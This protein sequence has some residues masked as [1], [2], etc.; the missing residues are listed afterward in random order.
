ML[1][2][3]KVECKTCEISESFYSKLS[4][5]QFKVRHAGHQVVEASDGAQAA[6][7]RRLQGATEDKSLEEET[8]R[9]VSKVIVSM[10]ASPSLGQP[11]VR[12][13]GFG[14]DLEEAFSATVPYNEAEKA[15]EILAKGEFVDYDVTGRRYT[16]EVGSVEY[17]LDA[18]EML[19]APTQELAEEIAPEPE[20]QVSEVPPAPEDLA[21]ATPEPPTV[22][23]A[24]EAEKAVAEELLSSLVSAPDTMEE[25][26]EAPAPLAA[27]E[28]ARQPQP[29]PV[30]V[31]PPMPPAPALAKARMKEAPVTHAEQKDDGYLLVSKSW[32][33]QGGTGNRDEAVRV[34][35]VLKEFRWRVEPIYT[36]GVI[37]DDMLCIETSRNQIS[38]TLISRVEGAG[39]RLTAVTIEQGKPV[40]WFRKHAGTGAD[41][42]ELDLESD[43]TA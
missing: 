36:I 18:Q 11:L 43:L 25:I 31:E 35:K 29:E 10:E 3:I 24:E 15:R 41:E 33:I 23:P 26:I 32:Y 4:V 1:Q 40:A 27:V 14:E 39:Y 17:E 38:R 12:I 2:K 16:W 34:S 9:K 6:P 20:A 13:R 7:A 8:A 42:S 21:A 5:E 22:V 30:H 19:A 28:Q 37:L